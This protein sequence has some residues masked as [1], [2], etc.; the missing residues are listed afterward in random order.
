MHSIG[1]LLLM[2]AKNSLL[3]LKTNKGKMALYILLAAMIVGLAVLSQH[4]QRIE[5]H[6]FADMGY[7]KLGF[8]AFLMLFLGFSVSKGTSKGDTFFG[9][10]DVNLLFVSPISPR[11]ILLYGLIKMVKI[12]FWAGFFLLYQTNSLGNAFGI[13]FGH[14]MLL[15]AGFMVTMVVCQVLC[16]VVY[17]NC[18]GRPARQRIAKALLIALF[19]PVLID[20]VARYFSGS[21]IVSALLGTANGAALRLTP[22]AGWMAQSTMSAIAG[23]WGPAT[24]WLLATLALGGLMVGYLLI[25]RVDYYEDVLVAT[26]TAFER[27]RAQKE[28]NVDASAVA[29]DR[30]IKIRRTG[31][32]GEGARALFGKHLLELTRE[33]GIGL[34]PMSS[35]MMIVGAAV[36][37]LLLR[38]EVDSLVLLQIALWVQV[39]RVGTGRALKELHKHYIYLIP[40]PATAKIA[41]SNAEG[42]AQSVVEGLLVFGIAG[43]ILGDGPVMIGATVSVYALFTLVLL[44]LNYLSLR[45]TGS[46][47]SEG[48]L[49]ALYYIAV[50]LVL[51]PGIVLGIWAGITVS[52]VLGLLVFGAWELLV[53]LACFA[54]AR[55]ALLNTDIPAKGIK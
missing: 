22:I 45:W 49:V 23:Q 41:W 4:T 33:R 31:I 7:L 44:A 30:A 51:A 54:G 13:G 24:G 26:E 47:I 18:N 12:A 8:F 17:N 50:V 34:L 52:T 29:D 3:E 6:T 35:L 21:D 32:H 55:G 27:A 42:M 37:A 1:Y 10:E 36:L 19:A 9:M 25:S 20:L 48:F 43:T 15:F 38:G 2:S 53:A 39:I 11:S 28:G 5:G 14:I 46:E 16:L 40:E